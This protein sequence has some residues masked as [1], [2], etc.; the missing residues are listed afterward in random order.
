MAV[1]FKYD[2]EPIIHN[3]S[4][5]TRCQIVLSWMA[6]KLSNEDSTLVQVIGLSPH[7]TSHY[8]H[9]C[10]ATSLW[11][12]GL[13]WLQWLNTNLR[14][15]QCTSSAD[16]RHSALPRELFDHGQPFPRH[17]Q[18]W[19]RNYAGTFPRFHIWNET[20]IGVEKIQVYH[21]IWWEYG[22]LRDFSIKVIYGT[23]L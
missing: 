9:S 17:D 19:W 2:L 5:C 23:P 10:W 16:N 20:E 11:P 22:I 13:S 14:T 3:T 7:T 4:L 18:L 15:I 1:I 21:V 8:L 12:Y 6:H